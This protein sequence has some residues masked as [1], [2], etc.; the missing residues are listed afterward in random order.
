MGESIFVASQRSIRTNK[1]VEKEYG[2]YEGVKG[3]RKG[4]GERKEVVVME[5]SE[6]RMKE[7][8]RKYLRDKFID[9]YDILHNKKF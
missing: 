3:S 2:E 7:E 8:E 4:G 6:Y 5:A 1:R 9:H